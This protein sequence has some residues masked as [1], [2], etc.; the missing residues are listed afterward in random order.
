M[1]KIPE[2]PNRLETYRQYLKE[3]N[4]KVV[5]QGEFLWW[6]FHDKKTL[7][8]VLNAKKDYF[9]KKEVKKNDD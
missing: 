2:N 6:V 5:K 4:R 1:K 3:T 9:E 8:E 7:E